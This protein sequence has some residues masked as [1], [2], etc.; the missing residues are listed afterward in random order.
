MNQMEEMI[1][2]IKRMEFYYDTIF[3]AVHNAPEL[4]EDEHI[5]AM[6]KSLTEYYEGGQWLK[7]FESDERGEIP[8]NLKRG[9]LSEDAVFDLLTD[10]DRIKKSMREPLKDIPLYTYDRYIEIGEIRLSDKNDDVRTIEITVGSA[11]FDKEIKRKSI[12]SVLKEITKLCSGKK[13]ELVFKGKE[14]SQWEPLDWAASVYLIV[15]KLMEEKL[16][17][18]FVIWTTKNENELYSPDERRFRTENDRKM[19]SYLVEMADEIVRV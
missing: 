17:D 13:A 1:Y 6:L 16:L 10:I 8:R 3:N 15:C 4:L 11:I 5:S 2:R 12:D 18:S 19:F 14:D 9:I 7:D